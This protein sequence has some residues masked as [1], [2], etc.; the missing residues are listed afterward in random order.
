MHIISKTHRGI[1]LMRAV[2]SYARVRRIDVD[3]VDVVQYLLLN[4][5]SKFSKRDRTAIIILT[6]FD[7][8]LAL[9]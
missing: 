5:K 6:A 8:S 2:S 4:I 3:V 7:F 1:A 9:E